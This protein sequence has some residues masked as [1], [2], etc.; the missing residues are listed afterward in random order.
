MKLNFDSLDL[1]LGSGFDYGRL[2]GL[3]VRDEF[4]LDQ[5]RGMGGA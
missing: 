1:S 3:S 5:V 4:L 2:I